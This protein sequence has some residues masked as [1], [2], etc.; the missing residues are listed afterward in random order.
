MAKLRLSKSEDQSSG[1]YNTFKHCI[2][3]P[4]APAAKEEVKKENLQE[5]LGQL[6]WHMQL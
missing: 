3:N 6:A 1:P 4:S 5:L 2:S